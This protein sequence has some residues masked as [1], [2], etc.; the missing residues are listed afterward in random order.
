MP[1]SKFTKSRSGVNGEE[2]YVA[3]LQL[4][5]T[6][7]GGEIHWKIVFDREEYGIATVSYDK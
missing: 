4:E 6:F 5:A 3:E 1:D 2:Y 7:S